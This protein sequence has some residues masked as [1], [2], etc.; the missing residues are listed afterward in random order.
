M[1]HKVAL[2]PTISVCIATYNSDST[3]ERCL[4]T[5]RS[6]DYPQSKIEIILGDGGSTD[7]TAIIAKRYRSKVVLVPRDKQHAE[8]NRGV[9]FNAAKSEL[10]L[11]LDH[12]NFLPNKSWLH[13]MVL[14]LLE[15]K[16]ILA[17]STCYYDYNKKYDLMDRYFALFGT[18][19]PLPFYLHKADRLPQTDKIWTL[20][21]NSID[22]GNYFEVSFSKNPREFPSVGSNGCLM[23]RE[24]VLNCAKADPDH[25]YPIDVLFDCVK[26]GHNKFAFVKISIIHLTHSRGLI[27]FIRRRVKFVNKY[28]F[29]EQSKRRWSVVMKGDEKMLAIY[30][31]YS[32]TVVKPTWDALRGYIKIHDAA[33][34]VHPIMCLVTTLLYGYTTVLHMISRKSITI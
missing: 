22:K 11:I 24:I 29:D 4:Q 30:I 16:E 18:S 15:N 5:I 34:F 14:P 6:Q 12:D 21:G 3:L 20:S 32:L 13:S 10:V 31:L 26:K 25:H 9:A 33:W 1:A 8:Y 27:Q 2:L 19:E 28:Q 23:R 17:S 7:K